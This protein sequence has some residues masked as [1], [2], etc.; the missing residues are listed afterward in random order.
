M[1]RLI[2]TKMI[3]RSSSRRLRPTSPRCQGHVLAVALTTVTAVLLLTSVGAAKETG[4]SRPPTLVVTPLTGVAFSGYQGGALSPQFFEYRLSASSGTIN[5]SI[6]APSWLSASS[7][8]GATDIKGVTIRFTVNPRAFDLPPGAYGPSVAFTNVS[9]GQ[10]SAF[11]PA[12]LVIKAPTPAA[13]TG[14]VPHRRK[15]YLLDDDGRYL[16]DAEGKK[17]PAQ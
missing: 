9:N 2:K 12:T 7:T 13:P 17:L 15:Q 8:F 14:E 3:G 11:R 6:R 10:G 5:Y 4:R 16:L 1:T